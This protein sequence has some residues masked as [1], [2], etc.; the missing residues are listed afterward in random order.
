MHTWISVGIM[1]IGDVPTSGGRVLGS[2]VR[3]QV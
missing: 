1:P 2:I 3:A